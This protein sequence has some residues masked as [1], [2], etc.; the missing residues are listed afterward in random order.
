MKTM[1]TDETIQEDHTVRSMSTMGGKM[2]KRTRK[3]MEVTGNQR[4]VLTVQFWLNIK[5]IICHE[6]VVFIPEM[7][8]GFYF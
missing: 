7:Q 4:R 6:R 2:E 1:N 8:S 3:D 5:R